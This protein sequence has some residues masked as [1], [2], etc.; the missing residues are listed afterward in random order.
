MVGLGRW[1]IRPVTTTMQWL[2]K[3]RL[4]ARI[5]RRVESR[6]AC[7]GLIIAGVIREVILI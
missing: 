1:N 6:V 7:M 2:H 4:R 5:T 3:G